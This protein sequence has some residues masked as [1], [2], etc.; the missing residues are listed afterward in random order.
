MKYLVLVFGFI[1]A[2]S[3]TGCTKGCNTD[4]GCSIENT[5]VTGVAPV[6]ASQLQCSNE[7]AIEAD[8]KN[9]VGK[10]NICKQSLDNSG[11]LKL[12]GPIC[13]MMADLVINGV[14]SVSIPASWG[15]TAANAKT[16]LK[17][18]VVTACQNI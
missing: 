9:I 6:I 7:S 16:L 11:K 10:L 1:V 17:N 13:S 3:F 14:A 4:I 15:C 18:V 2:L 5:V 8:L 12:P